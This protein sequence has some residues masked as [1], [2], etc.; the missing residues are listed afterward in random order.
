MCEGYSFLLAV[1]RGGGSEVDWGAANIGTAP[2]F[3][4]EGE[5]SGLFVDG[6]GKR[7]GGL[8]TV[9]FGSVGKNLMSEMTNPSTAWLSCATSVER[10]MASKL[11]SDGESAAI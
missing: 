9:H 2:A 11:Q 1:E 3:R 7:V 5:A 10:C 6:A 4:F 8:S